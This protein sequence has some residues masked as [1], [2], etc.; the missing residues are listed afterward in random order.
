MKP[1]CSRGCGKP[2]HAGHC[3]GQKLSMPIN[4]GAMSFSEIAERLGIP[5]QTAV[6]IYQRAL[7]KMARSPV[8]R[9]MSGLLYE[10]GVDRRPVSTFRGAREFVMAR[11]RA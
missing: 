9:E 1:P 4:G 5:K 10:Q 6:T 2:R 11:R 3:I 7:R 8:A